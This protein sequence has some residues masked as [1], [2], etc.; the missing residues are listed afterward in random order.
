MHPESLGKG[1]DQACVPD[2]KKCK[3]CPTIDNPDTK[4]LAIVLI[5]TLVLIGVCCCSFLGLTGYCCY[6]NCFHSRAPRGRGS[7]LTVPLGGQQRTTVLAPGDQQLTTPAAA[8][9]D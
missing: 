7:A 1:W 8:R 9:Q 2:A 4:K 6:K 3:C 5:V